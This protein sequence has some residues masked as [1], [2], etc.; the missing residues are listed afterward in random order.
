MK[1]V[2]KIGIIII[3]A[4]ILGV[5]IRTSIK[6]LNDENSALLSSLSFEKVITAQIDSIGG[7]YHPAKR[8]YDRIMGTIMTEEFI[9]LNDGSN[10]I[11]KSLAD[12]CRQKANDKFAPIFTDYATSYFGNPTWDLGEITAM[13]KTAQ[14]MIKSTG[15]SSKHAGMLKTIQTTTTGFIGAESVIARASKCTSSKSAKQ[16]ANEANSYSGYTLPASTR[17]RLKEAPETAKSNVLNYIIALGNKASSLNQAKNALSLANE[18]VNTFNS[19]PTVLSEIMSNLNYIIDSYYTPTYD[20]NYYNS[21]GSS[22]NT[23]SYNSYDSY[24]IDYDY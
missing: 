24:D 12:N 3:V 17:Q 14:E 18:Y 13:Q 11:S 6:A 16:I 2:I 19:C 23:G 10:A 20:Y 4:A 1:Q 15:A 8:S 5:A 9:T 7:D 22:S 21:S